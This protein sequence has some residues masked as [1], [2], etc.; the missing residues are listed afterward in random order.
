MG[1]N[2]VNQNLFIT[3]EAM[4][5]KVFFNPKIFKAQDL[6]QVIQNAEEICNYD[7]YPGNLEMGSYEWI[8]NTAFKID[9][10]Y[11]PDFLFLSYANPYYAAVYN[12]PDNLFWG[13]HIEALFSEIA[14]FLEETDYTPII[15]GTGGTYPLEEKRDLA[16]LESK[17]SY[18]WPGGVYASLYDASYKEIK[19]LEK[20]KSIQMIIP[21]ERISAMSEEPNEL[22]PD[23]FLVARRGYAFLEENSSNIYRVNARDAEIPVIAPRPI[24]NIGQ[25]NKLAKDLLASHKKVALI[26]MEGISVADFKWEHQICSNTYSWFTYLPEE[27][28]Y[29]AIGTGVKISDLKIFANFCHTGEP[30][31]NYLNKLNLTPKT[32]GGKQNIRSVAIGSRQN[33]TRIASGADIAIEC[34]L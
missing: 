20:D 21:Q 6:A 11:K 22:L 33:L 32:I 1:A 10:L 5:G 18:N 26:I 31:I 34:G 13:E 2:L 4:N 30:F 8:T 17:V 28:Q 12:S 29:L 7:K 27:F 15:V 14:R 23:Y 3:S 19:L 24:K 16:Y 25:I 9:E